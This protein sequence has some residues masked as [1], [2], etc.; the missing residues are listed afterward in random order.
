MVSLPSVRRNGALPSVVYPFKGI[1][2][3]LHHPRRIAGPILFSALKSSVLSLLAVIPLF[4]Y[5]FSAQSHLI[6]KIYLL[7]VPEASFP[8]LIHAGAAI[9]SGFLCVFEAFGIMSQIHI[10]I[11]GSYPDRFFESVLV[12]RNIIPPPATASASQDPPYEDIDGTKP[13]VHSVISP[14]GMMLGAAKED[15]SWG[16]FFVRPIVYLVTLPLS[17]VPMGGPVLFI[18]IQALFRGGES[19]K[20]YFDLYH[21]NNN[22]R[23]GRIEREFWKYQ[24]FGMVASALEMIPFA[25]FVF[26]FTSQIGA[27]MWI[28]DL[29]EGD[30]KLA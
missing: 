1:L 25:G 20:R 14:V 28:A 7:V 4:K 6:S 30:D 24:F 12:E 10:H 11:V 19:H 18:T 27:A 29:E 16:E 3:F 8:W 9:A 2:H 22:Q 17:V 13:K 5:G 23:Q 26:G 21:W 15:Q